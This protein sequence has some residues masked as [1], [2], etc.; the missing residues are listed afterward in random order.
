MATW[1]DVAVP[2]QRLPRIV[3]G[4]RIQLLEAIEYDGSDH[5]SAQ[6]QKVLNYDGELSTMADQS[7]SPPDQPIESAR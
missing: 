2:R 3:Y 5:F 6:M 4:G 1:L 7:S